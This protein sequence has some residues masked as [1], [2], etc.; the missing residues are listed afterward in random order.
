MVLNDLLLMI[1]GFA[2]GAGCAVVA[3]RQSAMLARARKWPSARGTILES[4]LVAD[5]KTKAVRCRVRY[6]FTV[7]SRVESDTP[8]IAGNSFSNAA[9][10]AAF[11]ARFT[12]GQTVDV[13]YDPADPKVNCLDRDD[14][15]G[16]WI[17][18]S[19]SAAAISFTV[20]AIWQ[21]VTGR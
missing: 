13:F 15:S 12:P 7:G 8:R 16:T 19:L 6:E 1:L 2:F 17:L 21:S 5:E 14:K 4:V 9:A 20:F 10:R 11:V 3:W 18:W